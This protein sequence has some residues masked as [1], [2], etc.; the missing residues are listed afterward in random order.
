[1]PSRKTTETWLYYL[2]D[3]LNAKMRCIPA[4]IIHIFWDSLIILLNPD[5]SFVAHLLTTDI[6]FW[7]LFVVC[8]ICLSLFVLYIVHLHKYEKRTVIYVKD[9]IDKHRIWNMSYNIKIF[10]QHVSEKSPILYNYV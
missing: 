2:F 7:V 1:M 6:V 9:V 5:S 3:L 8:I 4:D 10:M